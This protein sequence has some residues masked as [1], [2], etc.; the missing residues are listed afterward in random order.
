MQQTRVTGLARDPLWNLLRVVDDV[1]AEHEGAALIGRSSVIR[2]TAY[3]TWNHPLIGVQPG[4][5]E[6]SKS[7]I[8]ALRRPLSSTEGSPLDPESESGSRYR[9]SLVKHETGS[10]TLCRC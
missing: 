6:K 7:E 4:A 10:T 5:L 9:W 1:D 3:R 2:T 8:A